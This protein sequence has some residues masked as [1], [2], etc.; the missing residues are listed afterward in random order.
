MPDR[1]R[2]A[3]PFRESVE[4]RPASSAACRAELHKISR[5]QTMDAV[6]KL[7]FDFTR[8]DWQLDRSRKAP[9]TALSDE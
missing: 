7:E 6:V 1:S 8:V 9:K 5:I 2:T 4:Y 3:I